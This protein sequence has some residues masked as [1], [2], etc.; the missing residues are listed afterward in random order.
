MDSTLATAQR[1]ARATLTR[2]GALYAVKR[3]GGLGEAPLTFSLMMMV[4][5]LSYEEAL[6]LEGVDNV[7]SAQPHRFFILPDLAESETPPVFEGD[8]I[9][10]KGQPYRVSDCQLEDGAVYW[11]AVGSRTKGRSL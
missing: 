10:Y 9:T 3:D 4:E 11:V 1:V 8:V 6:R 5:K 7:A 2:F